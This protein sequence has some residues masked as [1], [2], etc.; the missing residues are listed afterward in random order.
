M[1]KAAFVTRYLQV[2]IGEALGAEELGGALPDPERNLF[3]MNA[4]SLML[5]EITAKLSDELGYDIP[6]SAFI[7]FPTIDSF[8]A[9][10]GELMG[11]Q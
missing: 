2:Q 6:S 8:V 5:L 4:E 10:L 3:D 7:D 11:F 1:L 9:N